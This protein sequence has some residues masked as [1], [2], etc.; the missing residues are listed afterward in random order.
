MIILKTKLF[1]ALLIHLPAWTDSW[2]WHI[3]HQIES[4]MLLNYIKIALRNILKNPG[5]SFINLFGLS[6][7]IAC[8]ILILL[9]VGDE[10]S[11]NQFHAN[12]K[13]LY[14]VYLNSEISDGL[15]TGNSMPYPLLEE[16]KRK[17]PDIKHIA[18]TNWG[19]GNL[20]CTG[21]LVVDEFV[22]GS[23]HIQDGNSLVDYSVGR[24][25]RSHTYN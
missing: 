22:P 7:G 3:N 2:K 12:Y 24:R 4:R 23:V 16:M 14:Q 13:N 21:C 17:S 10:L 8:S 6:I 18:R 25:R 19:E 15:V 5:Y 9:W 11:Y 20:L 1:Y